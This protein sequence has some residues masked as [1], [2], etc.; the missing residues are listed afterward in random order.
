MIYDMVRLG[1]DG[2]YWIG[3]FGFDMGYY[4]LYGKQKTEEEVINDYLRCL[5]ERTVANSMEMRE[6]KHMLKQLSS[7]KDEKKDVIDKDDDN[8]EK[9]E[10][11]NYEIIY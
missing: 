3:R 9:K 8:K 11:D 7:N 5:Q 6:I 10:E 1:I 2:V 4:L